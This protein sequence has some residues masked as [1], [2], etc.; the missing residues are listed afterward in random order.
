MSQM[1]FMK[2][3]KIHLNRPGTNFSSCAFSMRALF[4][5]ERMLNCFELRKPSPGGGRPPKI[6]NVLTEPEHCREVARLADAEAKAWRADLGPDDDD[7]KAN[8]KAFA[9]ICFTVHCAHQHSL[10]NASELASVAWARLSE[11]FK[12]TDNA[13]MHELNGSLQQASIED[14]KHDAE[15]HCSKFVAT[16]GRLASAEQAVSEQMQITCFTNGLK[17]K[18]KCR[19]IVHN[20]ATANHKTLKACMEHLRDL[21]CAK[22]MASNQDGQ[23]KMNVN[24]ETKKTWTKKGPQTNEEEMMNHQQSPHSQEQHYPPHQ[25]GRRGRGRFGSR[26]RRG[27]RGRR[28]GRRGGRAGRKRNC[29]GKQRQRDQEK[30]ARKDVVCFSCGKKGHYARECHHLDDLTDKQCNS[31]LEKC[32]QAKKSKKES[33]HVNKEDEDR[34]H[35]NNASSSDEE[36]DIF[37]QG[38]HMQNTNM[39][40]KDMM[41]L[42]DGATTHIFNDKNYFSHLH[43]LTHERKVSVGKKGVTHT[44]TH[45]GEAPMTFVLPGGEKKKGVSSGVLCSP[46]SSLSCT[47]QSKI[48]GMGCRM[49][50][51]KGRTLAFKNDKPVMHFTMKNRLHHAVLDENH[52]MHKNRKS[53]N[54][55]MHQID[56]SCKNEVP[57]CTV[58]QVYGQIDETV[59][60]HG[61]LLHHSRPKLRRTVKCTTGL[62]SPKQLKRAPCAACDLTSTKRARRGVPGATSAQS[63]RMH[64]DTKSLMRSMRGCKCFVVCV[65]EGTRKLST[66]KAKK[67]SQMPALTRDVLRKHN[68]VY[69]THIVEFRSDNGS[70]FTAESL[71]KHLR[72]TGVTFN[73][74]TP[75]TP[76]QNG[77]SERTMQTMTTKMRTIIKQCGV[78]LRHWCCALDCVVHAMN[79][80]PHSADVTKTP[81]ELHHERKPD[82]SNLVVFGCI[83]VLSIDR[84]LRR[85]SRMDDT[86]QHV[87]MLGCDTRHGTCVVSTDTGKMT[88]KA[89]VDKWHQNVFHSA[90]LK[91]QLPGHSGP[92][93]P[94]DSSR[95]SSTNAPSVADTSSLMDVVQTLQKDVNTLKEKTKTFSSS[96]LPLQETEDTKTEKEVKTSPLHSSP[97]VSVGPDEWSTTTPQDEKSIKVLQPPTKV[98]TRASK[99]TT[100][101]VPPAIMGRNCG[102]HSLMDFQ[103]LQDEEGS[104][105][106][107]NE[108]EMCFHSE[109]KQSHL[110]HRIDGDMGETERMFA[111][112][113]RIEGDVIIKNVDV[114]VHDI[115][116]I[117]KTFREAITGPEKRYWIPSIKDEIR[118]LV[119]RHTWDVVRRPKGAKLV[120]TKWVFKKETEPRWFYSL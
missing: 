3:V 89:N 83:G 114:T 79:R 106:N 64:A 28:G 72:K 32:K 42:D 37:D 70:E 120:T 30:R 84:R 50:T 97:I 103:N 48:D 99:R 52:D 116:N 67:K 53:M 96:S 1:A 34:R 10:D 92:V 68:N 118:S 82:L 14:H 100:K 87:R 43:P 22:K 45:K 15:S 13:S 11:R 78:S 17:P 57:E 85:P 74:S 86:G 61:K 16:C 8:D 93:A 29:D 47:S 108:D 98:P 4:R 51:L 62:K 5:A 111:A 76:E 25:R 19:S 59:E 23:E 117:P 46:D 21:L 66:A 77:V 44:A 95:K 40:T 56:A 49:E 2:N 102:L 75:R 60:L 94:A 12:P 71:Q 112:L 58:D 26:G 41:T 115:L 63:E 9:A 31:V 73:P 90:T 6:I 27:R 104:I 33:M 55:Q 105:T 88:K 39:K 65:H 69:G 20:L 81:C 80:T 7:D 110:P 113:D 91:Q 38:C 101:N 36:D 107:A 54:M 109:M 35:T 24:T 119:K 18:R